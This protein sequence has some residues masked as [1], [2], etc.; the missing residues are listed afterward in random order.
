MKVV[1]TASFFATPHISIQHKLPHQAAC[2]L[3]NAIT[4]T[5]SPSFCMTTFS[6]SLSHMTAATTQADEY[7]H[8]HC[9]DC[10]NTLIY[11]HMTLRTLL[12]CDISLGSLMLPMPEAGNFVE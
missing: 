9:S 10:R 12:T 1:L 4:S 11:A 2:A 5:K 7:W 6:V 3:Y 8:L